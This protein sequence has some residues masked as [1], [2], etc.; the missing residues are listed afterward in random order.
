MAGPGRILPPVVLCLLASLNTVT[1]HVTIRSIPSLIPDSLLAKV[2]ALEE[3]SSL[4]AKDLELPL[5]DHEQGLAGIPLLDHDVP[6]VVSGALE[7]VHHLH[8]PDQHARA[9]ARRPTRR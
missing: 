3:G 4:Q 1:A 7:D 5:D 8:E 2:D 9:R 6:R